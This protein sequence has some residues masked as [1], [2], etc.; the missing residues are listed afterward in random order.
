MIILVKSHGH[1]VPIVTIQTY[2]DLKSNILAGL[3]KSLL[4]ECKSVLRRL[5]NL[6]G[7]NFE[8]KIEKAL[9]A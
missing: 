2:R 9:S 7:H 5:E 4:N 3:S 1:T 6:S 8:A